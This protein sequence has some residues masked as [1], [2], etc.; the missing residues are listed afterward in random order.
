MFGGRGGYQ[1]NGTA[2]VGGAGDGRKGN[3]I[4]DWLGRV[5]G[6]YEAVT[7]QGTND[8]PAPAAN[9]VLPAPPNYALWIGIAVAVLV[10]GLLFF[11]RK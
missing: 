11:K 8:G 1:G 2:T 3:A 9:K 5:T 4:R 10:V 7:G 6:A